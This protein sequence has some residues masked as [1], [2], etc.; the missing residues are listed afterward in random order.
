MTSG[1][2]R[3]VTGDVAAESLGL[4]LP[5]E[6][7][8]VDLRGPTAPGYA[9]A[10]PDRVVAVVRPY[11]A[12]AEAA[13]VTALVDCAPVG[14]G[15]N[16]AVLR[17]LAE[18]TS[19]RIIAP[20]GTYRE[21]FIPAPIATLSA[22]ALA[23]RWV[24]ELTQG[25]EGTECRAGFIKLAMSE[26][27]PTEIEVRNLRAAALT[28]RQTGAAIASHTIG[29]TV[30]RREMDTLERAGHDLRRFIWVHAHTEP[31]TSAHVEAARRGAWL[32]F[33]AIGAESWHPQT[34]LLE[35]V[36]ALIEAGYTDHVLLSHDA[37]WYD[38]SQP[39]GRPPEGFR[40]YTALLEQFIPALRARGV[41][42]DTIRQIT[43]TNPARAFAMP[44]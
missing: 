2:I 40:G 1:V 23:G 3:T 7:L 22:E 5:H 38:P 19:I 15:R 27:G 44:G 12:A 16:I 6:H 20:T 26:D 4:M 34:A 28:S 30:A 25:M 36:L 29:G 33:D 35:S 17:R 9:E 41:P 43:V 39:D 11:L 21:G 18:S 24:D 32:E 8:F 31:E 37:G 10:D 42:E 13:G 14:V